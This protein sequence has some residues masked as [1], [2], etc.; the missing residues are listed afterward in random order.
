MKIIKLTVITITTIIGIILFTACAALM[1]ILLLT[2]YNSPKTNV[3][4]NKTVNITSYA[5]I[6]EYNSITQYRYEYINKDGDNSYIIISQEEDNP[7]GISPNPY[8]NYKY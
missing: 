6:P 7:L 1:S 4:I 5:T 3:N 8:K 2:S